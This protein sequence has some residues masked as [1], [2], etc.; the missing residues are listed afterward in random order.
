[1]SDFHW[2]AALIKI[3]I[4]HNSETC[5]HEPPLCIGKVGHRFIWTSVGAPNIC[6][7][8]SEN[9]HGTRLHNYAQHSPLC[10]SSTCQ[11]TIQLGIES[12]TCQRKIHTQRDNYVIFN[13]QFI[14]KTSCWTL[15]DIG[16]EMLVHHI[17]IFPPLGSRLNP[18]PIFFQ[19]CR[20]L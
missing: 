4:H 10:S 15:F 14:N 11:T 8:T 18:T 7:A 13:I 16:K 3:F 9:L 20:N 1:M 2:E 6:W 5:T 12:F 17:P 19:I